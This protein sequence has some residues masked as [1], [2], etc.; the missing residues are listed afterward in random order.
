M[1]NIDNNEI[2]SDTIEIKAIVP[3]EE[4]VFVDMVF[5]SYE[6]IAALTLHE[7]EQGLIILDV[8]PGTREMVLEILR[9]FQKEFPVKIIYDE[10]LKS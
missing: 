8:T 6:G 4:V 5:K 2:V 1:S 3:P 9:D 10:G 7:A